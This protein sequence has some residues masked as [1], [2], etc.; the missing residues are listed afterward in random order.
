M[1]KT[2]IEWA[3]ATWN[4]WIGCTKISPGCANCYAC[5]RMWAKYW[6]KGG[7]RHRTAESYWQQPARW[8][9]S[10]KPDRHPSDRLAIFP[11]LCDWLDDEVPIEWLA[12]F[13]RVIRDTQ[14]LDWLLLT[15]RPEF[16]RQRLDRVVNRAEAMRG[17]GR[18]SAAGKMALGWLNGAT[19]RNVSLGV[20]AENQ[21]TFDARARSLCG[22]W[23][24]RR[25]LSC[26]PLLGPIDFGADLLDCGGRPMIH[27]VI[28]GGESGPHARPCN[29]DW[30]R[31]IIRQC[32]A[33]KVPC[34]VK[35]LGRDPQWSGADVDARWYEKFSDPKGGN[36]EEWPHDLRVRQ[37]PI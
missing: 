23:A 15:K 19:P 27:W 11:S 4:P 12:D 17:N 16:F 30:I 20:S 8:N 36:M 28:V 6:G 21:E 13:L 26:E 32:A 2:K 31:D 22:Q 29:V 1:K 10:E 24:F 35:Q 37:F 9:A 14:N 34:F 7:P 25:F 33:A 18:I 5:S 3:D